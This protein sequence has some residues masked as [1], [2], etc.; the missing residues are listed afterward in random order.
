M[1]VRRKAVPAREPLRMLTFPRLDGGLDLSELDYRVETRRSPDMKNLWWQDGVLQCRDGQRLVWQPQEPIRG[2]A[3]W[4]EPFAGRLVFHAGSCLYAAEPDEFAMTPVPLAEDVPENP[5]TFFRYGEHLY[6]KNRGG[7]YRMNTE[8][9]E[10]EKVEEAAYVPTVLLNAPP[11]NPEEG[12][13]YQPVNR[14]SSLQ[15][16]CYNAKSGV[17]RYILPAGAVSVEEIR[18]DGTVWKPESYS[19]SGRIVE[20]V[21]A[22]PVQDPPV[23]NTVEIVFSVPGDEA[24]QQ[25]MEACFAAVHGGGQDLC[26]LLGGGASCPNR[27]FWNGGTGESMDPTYWP[28]EHDLIV[29]DASDAVTGFGRQYGDL[30]VLKE[31]SLWRLEMGIRQLEG[32]DTPSFGAS[33]LTS[34]VGCDLPGTAALIENNLV[35]C[36]REKG[37]FQVRSSSAAY[38]TNVRCLS[39]RVHGDGVRGLL[40][41]LRKAACVTGFDDGSRYWLCA[42]DRVYLWDY[43]I[44]D[45]SD[46]SW[47]YLEGVAP[48]A[49]FRADDGR[50]FH[51]DTQGRLSMFDRSFSDYGAAIEKVYRFPTLDFGTCDRRKHVESVLLSLRADTSTDVQLR[52][53]AEGSSRAEP[54][55]LR[56]RAWRLAPRDLRSR[57][58]NLSPFAYT[59]RRRPCLR[60]VRHFSM[61]LRNADVGSDLAVV[62]AQVCFRLA[63]RER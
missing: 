55:P 16:V 21:S 3:A 29:G 42:D 6:Y 49:F 62:T 54:V 45:F 9:R 2:F 58:L 34:L 22:P 31:R 59:F 7:F 53:E 63:E 12:D 28:V 27:V 47:F 60:R 41:D 15:R 24:R 26:V 57:S 51:L 23:N 36:S 33:P 5:G 43:A 19:V 35:F 50:L 30:L 46:P 4:Q 37:V 40:R 18:V 52:Y 1:S 14:L 44:S 48:V 20:F 8:L 61:T 32:R 11:E 56:C 25:L 39:S 17:K 38:E 13:L 10:A